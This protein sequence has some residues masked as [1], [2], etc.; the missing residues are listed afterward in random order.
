MQMNILIIR[1]FVKI[2]EVIATHIDLARAIE[3]IGRRQE[4]QAEQIAASSPLTSHDKPVISVRQ[5]RCSGRAYL[6]F[7]AN[8]QLIAQ[9]HSVWLWRVV[10]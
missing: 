4:D 3:D 8:A 2:R 5:N 1:A 7:M 10:S 9:G 6:H